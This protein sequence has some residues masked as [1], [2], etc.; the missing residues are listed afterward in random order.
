MAKLHGVMAKLHGVKTA[1][2]LLWA[3]K[4]GKA[5]NMGC[6]LRIYLYV[7]A[8][9][10]NQEIEM[11][12]F[13]WEG[14][15]LNMGRIARFYVSLKSMWC[16]Y[17]GKIHCYEASFINLCFAYY[18]D[19]SSPLRIWPLQKWMD[20]FVKFVPNV[21]SHLLITYHCGKLFYE[22]D[23]VLTMKMLLSGEHTGFCA[24]N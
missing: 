10:T 21:D 15:C 17:T 3:L 1:G 24:V 6:H 9:N 5:E 4:F 16:L 18:S 2:T 12:S 19:V 7:H 20:W 11:S 23:T 22:Q 8:F 13:W 14:G